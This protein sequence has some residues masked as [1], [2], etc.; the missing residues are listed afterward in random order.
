M[1]NLMNFRMSKA[2]LYFWIGCLTVFISDSVVLQ[3]MNEPAVASN[4]HPMQWFIIIIRS[5]LGGL[6]PL[7]ALGSKPT[8]TEPKP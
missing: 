1:K 6:I 3:V 4:M 2:A 5:L 7:K 8:E